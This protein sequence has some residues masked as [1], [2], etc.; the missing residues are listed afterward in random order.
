[1]TPAY[2]CPYCGRL[3]TMR[4]RATRGTRGQVVKVH[5]IN[6]HDCPAFRQ[7]P[8]L[9]AGD[10]AFRVIPERTEADIAYALHRYRRAVR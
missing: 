2:P 3:Y 9:L 4:Y 7:E 8:S 1:M 5:D 10:P 6:D